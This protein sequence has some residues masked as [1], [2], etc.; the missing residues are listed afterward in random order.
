MRIFS[1]LSFREN[2]RRWGRTERESHWLVAFKTFL[3]QGWELILESNYVPLIW[4]GIEPEALWYSGPTL[5]PLSNTAQ[6]LLCILASSVLNGNYSWFVLSFPLDSK[7]LHS[8][9]QLCNIPQTFICSKLHQR[10]VKQK[11]LPS[12]SLHSS[13]GEGGDRQ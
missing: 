3:N 7:L 12:G 9:T 8:K 1:P 4:T 5:Q 6:G 10:T 13:W 11:F 2:G